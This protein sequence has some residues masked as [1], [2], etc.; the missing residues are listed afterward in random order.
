M[1]PWLGKAW[2]LAIRVAP[3]RNGKGIPVPVKYLAGDGQVLAD[4]E[5]TQGGEELQVVPANLLCA[6]RDIPL[7]PGQRQ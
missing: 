5:V 6:D 1:N 3:V 2:E 4:P 7:R